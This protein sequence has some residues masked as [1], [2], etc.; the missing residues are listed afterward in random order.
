M[1]R[2]NDG[3]QSRDSII[4]R[5]YDL[6]IFLHQPHTVVEISRELKIDKSCTY[7][8]LAAV[9]GRFPLVS[10]ERRVKGKGM[11]PREYWINYLGWCSG[12][13]TGRDM[14]NGVLRNIAKYGFN[15]EVDG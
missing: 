1:N 11:S 9:E 6:L 13:E 2:N 8:Y 7:G 15:G 14:A 5:C 4:G 10:R 12:A 3:Q